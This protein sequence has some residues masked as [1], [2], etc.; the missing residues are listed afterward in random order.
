MNT[1]EWPPY[2]TVRELVHAHVGQ[3]AVVIGGGDS[4]PKSLAKAPAD[5]I[6]L[7][8]NDHGFL[9]RPCQY[10]V[11]LDKGASRDHSRG[12]P[13]ISRHIWGHYRILESPAP[14]SGIAAA[15][16]ARIMGC[17]PIYVIGMDCYVGGTYFHDRHAKSS[18]KSI[19]RQTHVARWRGFLQKFPADY[20]CIG[21]AIDGLKSMSPDA[22][23][24]AEQLDAALRGAFVEFLSTRDIVILGSKRPFKKGERAELRPGEA[25]K[26][27]RER[28][29][30]RVSCP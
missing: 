21:G 6:A 7:S 17:T 23:P 20:R 13:V 28:L 4:A 5:A 24:S 8:A 25:S 9:L 18:G 16:V 15:W 1:L 3:P 10:K 27:V 12:V 26:L 11:S 14:N 2:R 19:N 30:R 22:R 29:A